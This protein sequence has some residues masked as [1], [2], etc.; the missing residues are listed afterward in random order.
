MRDDERA[1]RLADTGPSC[2][3]SRNRNIGTAS[4]FGVRPDRFD[5]QVESIDAVDLARY[6]VRLIRRNKLGGGEVVQTIDARWVSPS[7]IKNTAHVR[8]S[9]REN[10]TI[11]R[12]IDGSA[13]TWVQPS[14]I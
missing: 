5:H 9:V 12:K 13:G 8:Y 7:C 10:S 14:R 6:G 2:A 4:V 3:V 1:K 11:W